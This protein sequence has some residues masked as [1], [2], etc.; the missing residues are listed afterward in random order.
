MANCILTSGFQLSCADGIGG[1]K[2]IYIANY[3]DDTTYALDSDNQI[4]GVTSANTYY[5]FQVPVESSGWAEE[6]TKSIENGTLFFT[7]TL[8]F[9][10][11][12]FTVAE[13]N[14]VLLLAKAEISAIILLQ[15]GIY[16][17]LGVSN[18]GN[19]VTDSAGSGQAFGDR[20]GS[21]FGFEFKQP[22]NASI[23]S[24]AAFATLVI[25]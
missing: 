12:G 16:V 25:A 2:S 20:L 4:T 18:P 17:T 10:I 1:I 15:S 8:T 22:E 7:S 3:N 9:P 14:L 13:R 11:N 23:M 24:A 19:M 6:A 5:E 21:N